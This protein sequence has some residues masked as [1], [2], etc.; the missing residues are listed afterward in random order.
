MARR[1][2]ASGEGSVYWIDKKGLWAGQVTL[3]DGSRKFKYSKRQEAVKEWLLTQRSEL[4]QGIYTKK[5][6]ITVSDFMARY[7]ETVAKNTLRPTTLEG[8][9]GQIKNHINPTIGKI[10][11]KDL[12]PD[13]IQSLYSQKLSQGL[14]RRTVQL[15]HVNLRT[16]LKQAVKWGLV[17]RNVTD[18]VQA[19]RPDKPSHTFFTKEQ[20]NKFLE[21]VKG[22]KWEVIFILLVYCGLREGEVL[23]IHYEDCDMVNRVINVRH[24]VVTLKKGLMIGEPKTKASKRAVTLPKIAYDA[25]KAHLDQLDRNHGLIFTTS[26]DTPIYPRNF[27]RHFKS[28]LVEAGLPDIRVHDLRHSHASL[29]LAS[30]V[31]PKLVQERLGHS[32]I[33]LTLDTYS[34]VIPS[35]QEEVAKRMDDLMG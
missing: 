18:F 29:L 27:I 20:L 17:A 19:P 14:S 3:P 24:T 15:L 23:G 21:S 4:R 9:L 5:D 28:R 16:A 34:H 25:L 2:R 31:N 13:H 30:G 33:A 35:L 26:A 7:I 32:T 12:R 22:D 10:K 1:R 11:L 6:N 8:N